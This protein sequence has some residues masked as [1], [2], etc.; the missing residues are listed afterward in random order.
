[1]TL[2]GVMAITL[3]CFTKFGKPAFKH[4]TTDLWRNLCV[5]LLYFVVPVRFRHKESS[6]SLSYLLL[7]FL[8]TLY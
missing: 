3:R 4:V 2:N 5:S 6:H 1:M 7:S 8:L